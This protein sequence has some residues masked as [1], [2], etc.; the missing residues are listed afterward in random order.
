MNSRPEKNVET[1]SWESEVCT[2]QHF[3]ECA[4]PLLYG[5]GPRS[6]KRFRPEEFGS[7]FRSDLV[8]CC[9]KTGVRNVD[10]R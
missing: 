4:G 3:E 10:S 7:R 1:L 5:R 8:S 6:F 9:V 2:G